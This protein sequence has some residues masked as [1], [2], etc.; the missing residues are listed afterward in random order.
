[1]EEQNSMPVTFRNCQGISFQ[2]INLTVSVLELWKPVSMTRVIVNAYLLENSR[3]WFQFPRNSGRCILLGRRQGMKRCRSL[4]CCQSN[5]DS[6]SHIHLAKH[7]SSNTIIKSSAQTSTE[8]T[9]KSTS[10]PHS[11][12][13][14]TTE[15]H[16]NMRYFYFYIKIS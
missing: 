13:C 14:T 6:Y 5:T 9:V 16:V 8:W 10:L 12:T 11:K 15:P 1:M 3:K 2:L 7:T 4:V